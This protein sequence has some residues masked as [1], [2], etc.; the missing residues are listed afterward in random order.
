MHK[1]NEYVKYKKEVCKIIEIKANYYQ[2]KDYYVL[3]PVSDTSLKNLIPI[4]SSCLKKLITK[5]E[6][7][8]LISKMANIPIIDINSKQIENEYKNLL[9]SGKYEDL[10]KVIKTTYLRNQERLKNHK[11]LGDKD[12]YYFT[13]AENYLYQ[14][15]SI[16]LNMNIEEVKNYIIKAITNS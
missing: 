15:F 9:S 8:K 13:K 14:E 1:I 12:E 5:D 10:I 7:Q 3:V 4:D 16:V 11:R 6:I 2:N